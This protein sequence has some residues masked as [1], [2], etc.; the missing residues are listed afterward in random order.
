MSH[1]NGDLR[2]FKED[3]WKG[4]NSLIHSGTMQ[5]SYEFVDGGMIKKHS[6]EYSQT[7]LDFSE[8]FS[9]SSL[10][11]VGSIVE[12]TNIIKSCIKLSKERL[13]IAI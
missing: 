12:N 10:G 11:N 9:I 8:R 4:L 1:L 13:G 3:H 5:L 7:L 6:S 2:K